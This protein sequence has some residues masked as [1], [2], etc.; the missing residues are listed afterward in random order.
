MS[1]KKIALGSIVAIIILVSAFFVGTLYY[2]YRSEIGYDEGLDSR[3]A[4]APGLVEWE[5]EA[6]EPS[7]ISKD[8]DLASD[9][10]IIQERMIIYNAYLSLETETIEEVLDK[11][12]NLANNYDGYVAGSSR[13]SYG[14]RII[15]DITIRIPQDKFQI[16]I[17]EIEN[18][19]KILD[20]RTTSDDV[21]ERYIDLNARLDNLQRQEKRLQEILEFATTVEEILEVER[22]LGN[23]RGTIESL[24]GQLNYLERSISMSVISVHLS[25]PSTQ[26]TPTELDWSEVF[27]TAIRGFFIVLRGLII[28]IISLLPLIIVGVIVYYIYKKRKQKPKNTK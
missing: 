16:A 15:A 2:P 13:S 20:A 4:I 19:G 8:Y 23:I 6:P 21:T 22:E 5:G 9:Q 14:N 10:K 1:K 18:Y 17:H 3:S 26:F 11:I 24:Q 12:E 27:E 7:P 25:E 28:M